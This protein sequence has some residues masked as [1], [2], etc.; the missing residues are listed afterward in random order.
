MASSYRLSMIM[1]LRRTNYLCSSATSSMSWRSQ[2][3]SYPISSTNY[4]STG[5]RCASTRR[6]I[7]S[8]IHT[9]AN[10]SRSKSDNDKVEKINIVGSKSSS[11]QVYHRNESSTT[12][13]T[14]DD[15][16]ITTDDTKIS[17]SAPDDAAAAASDP[18]TPVIQPTSRHKTTGV[19]QKQKEV[20]KVATKGVDPHPPAT[21]KQVV[22]DEKMVAN[23]LSAYNSSDNRTTALSAEDA[24]EACVQAW[25][26]QMK[27]SIR[28]LCTLIEVCNDHRAYHKDLYHVAYWAYQQLRK[29]S[30][31]L[32][33]ETY[34]NIL[35]LCTAN[36][37][38]DDASTVLKHFEEDGYSYTSSVYQ[39]MV[40]LLSSEKTT[41][42]E[43]GR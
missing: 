28:Q 7:S 22:V 31:A 32:S 4:N 39:S 14:I 34:E 8:T 41:T 20:I 11:T 37:A 17:T 1:M 42:P 6:Y 15:I 18:H 16:K 19:P 24:V 36:R 43:V 29:E 26:G 33:I 5:Y 2:L 30:R 3:S 35:S 38:I 23:V 21:G 9:H 25:R 12:T 27:L 10:N 40:R 13:A